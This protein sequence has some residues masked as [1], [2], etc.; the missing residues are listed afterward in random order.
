MDDAVSGRP[1]VVTVAVARISAIT[2]SGSRAWYSSVTS[3]SSSRSGDAMTWRA[4]ARITSR[5]VQAHGRARRAVEGELDHRIGREQVSEAV[6]IAGQHQLAA[7][8]QDIG[9]RGGR[10]GWHEAVPFTITV[11]STAV[12]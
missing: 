1:V 3:Y 11:R 5:P 4:Y 7:A 10:G 2:T 12:H 9:G 6:G 8:G